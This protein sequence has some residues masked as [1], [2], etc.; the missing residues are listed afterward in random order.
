[1]GSE[2]QVSADVSGAP[3]AVAAGVEKALGDERCTIERRSP[4]GRTLGFTTRKTMLS[5]ELEGQVIVSPSAQGSRIDLVLDT[6]HNR[7]TAV[8][9]GAK[10]ARSAKRLLERI[11]AAL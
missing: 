7:P 1:M 2:A 11:T 9:D 5:W 10:N 6:H 3:D 4:D 8:L